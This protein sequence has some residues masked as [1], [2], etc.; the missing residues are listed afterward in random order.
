MEI[1]GLDRIIMEHSFFAGLD[2]GFCAL[3]CG[4]AKNLHFEAGQCLFHEG[5]RP[6][7]SICCG[8]AASRCS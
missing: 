7:S 8:M 3:I 4:C 1:K 2:G 6:I 5:Q